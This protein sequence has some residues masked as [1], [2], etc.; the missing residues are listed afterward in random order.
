MTMLMFLHQYYHLV[1]KFNW[2]YIDY[3]P[4]VIGNV[5]DSQYLTINKQT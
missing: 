2:L 3:V 5:T 1:T 4:R